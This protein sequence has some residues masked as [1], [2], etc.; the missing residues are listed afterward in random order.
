MRLGLV[1]NLAWVGLC[2]AVIAL[3]VVLLILLSTLQGVDPHLERAALSLGS[4]PVRTLLTVTVPLAAPGIVSAALFAFLASIDELVIA[5]F[6]TGPRTQTLP[7]RIWNSLHL[8]RGADRRRGQRLP[9]RRHGAGPGRRRA[10]AAANA[11]SDLMDGNG[12][13]VVLGAGVAGLAT[14]VYLQRA[15]RTVTV[16]DPLGPAGG[17]SFGNA[18]MISADTAAP[19]AMPG[20]LRRVPRLARRPR[21]AADRPSGLRAGRDALADALGA[22]RAARPCDGDLGRHAR[23]APGTLSAA[24]PSWW[25]RACSPS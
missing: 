22:R 1:G 24:G 4:G 3:P 17:A 23:A 14:A 12:A 19:I 15:G 25:G 16:L 21:R 6:L 13:V 7:V 2:H 10:V 20:M 8:G 9:H 18:G 5:L 11:G